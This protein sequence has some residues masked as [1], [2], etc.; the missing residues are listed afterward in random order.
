LVNPRAISHYRLLSEFERLFSGRVYK[1]RVSNQGDFIAIHFYED[2]F[3]IERSPKLATGITQR[4]RVVNA[5]NRRRGIDARRGDGTFGE[6]IPGVIPVLEPEFA[7]ARGPIATVEIGTEVKI[8][9]KAMIKQIDR[10][11]SDLC[12]Q[13]VQ[14]KR[15]GGNPICVGIVGVNY[16]EQ[17]TSHEGD[18]HYT[19]SGKGGVPH[20]LQ[21]APE[22]SRRLR[23]LA[24][25]AFDEFLLLPYRA[26]NESPFLFEWVNYGETVLDYGAVLT[27]ISSKYQARF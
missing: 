21:E 11:V 24:A 18:R 25:P 19:T 10:V 20:P 4:Q 12:N 3:A 7:V 9:A 13:V 15:G 16:A 14:F 27:R 26:A 5:Q 22:A 6:I 23:A 2:L 17:Y 1:H 8:L